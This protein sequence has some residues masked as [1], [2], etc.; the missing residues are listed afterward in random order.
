TFMR[1]MSGL[2]PSNRLRRASHNHEADGSSFAEGGRGA[3]PVVGNNLA[4]FHPVPL[5]AHGRSVS[6]VFEPELPAGLEAL[7]VAPRSA[8]AGLVGVS[9]ETPYHLRQPA[10][11]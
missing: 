8:C 11:Q 1:N 6:G 3:C 5:P 9:V 7:P 4:A 10:Q 2:S